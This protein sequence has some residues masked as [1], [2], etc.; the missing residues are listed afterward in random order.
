MQQRFQIADAAD[1]GHLVA[2]MLQEIFCL[3]KS[4]QI[5]V[6]DSKSLETH[7]QSTKVISDPRLRV[8]IARLREMLSL[9]EIQVRWTAGAYQLA[10]CLT[11]WGASADLLKS[12]LTTG[13][14][15]P[16]CLAE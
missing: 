8:D 12:V 16:E 5:I 10:D 2:N 11:K 14:L 4:P 3:V 1:Q 9:G 6:T 13:V 15:P 7:L